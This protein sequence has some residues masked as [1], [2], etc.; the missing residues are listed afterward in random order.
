MSDVMS[1]KPYFTVPPLNDPMPSPCPPALGVLLFGTFILAT[2]V[3]SRPTSDVRSGGRRPLSLQ[4]R[5]HSG[6]GPLAA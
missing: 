3:P 4:V 6:Q 5:Q 2:S 1:L